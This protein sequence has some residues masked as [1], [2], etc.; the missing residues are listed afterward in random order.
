MLEIV[1]T[2]KILGLPEIGGISLE[3]FLPNGKSAPDCCSAWNNSWVASCWKRSWWNDRKERNN[4]FVETI[5]RIA[6]RHREKHFNGKAW[7]HCPSESAHIRTLCGGTVA[8]NKTHIRRSG[9]VS[10]FPSRKIQI[11]LTVN[12]RIRHLSEVNTTVT[13]KKASSTVN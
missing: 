4:T 1:L 11:Y 2:P 10:C 5:H 7:T 9:T 3:P 13:D 6:L 8:I 12:G